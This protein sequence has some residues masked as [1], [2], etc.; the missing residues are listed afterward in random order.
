MLSE[1]LKSG[2]TLEMPKPPIEDRQLEDNGQILP[3][4]VEILE[5]IPE[6]SEIM[7]NEVREGTRILQPNMET[8]KS[9]SLESIRQ[10]NIE[11]LKANVS[12][13]PNSEYRPLT[14][15]EAKRLKELTNL[16]DAVI[17]SIM[18]GE[19]GTLYLKCRNAELAGETHEVTGVPY[20][21]KTIVINGVEITVVVPEFPYVFETNIPKEFWEAGDRELFK[22]CTEE[23]R[24]YLE[25]HPEMRENFTE[26][27]LQQIENGEPYIK[28]YTWHHTEVPG[29]MQLVE[30]K[31]HALS[32]HTGG[33]AIWCG[34]IR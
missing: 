34:G 28:G 19:D 26:E 17:E 12:E 23:L 5:R 32:G 31:T 21:E 3:E 18:V 33:N 7:L 4:N 13:T 25:E 30:T 10:S 9:Q 8:I 27:Q 20:V 2:K 14:E 16:P 15:E 11:K 29:K 24:K 22:K 1:I 6:T